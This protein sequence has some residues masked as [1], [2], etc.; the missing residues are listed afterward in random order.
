MPTTR[1]N[2]TGFCILSAALGGLLAGCAAGEPVSPSAPPLAVGEYKVV[3]RWPIGQEGRWDYV[4]VDPRARRLYLP[5]SDRVMVLDADSGKALGQ[6]PNTVGVH[7]VAL[8]PDLGRGFTSNGTA[9]TVTVFDLKT[10]AVL[11]EVYAGE[12]PDAI[13]YDPA[14]QRVFAFNGRSHDATAIVGSADPGHAASVRLAL[15]GKPEFAVVDGRGQLYVNIEDTGEVVSLDTRSLR[16]TARWP[17]A[18]GTEP[19]GLAIDPIHRR[20]FIGCGNQLMVVMN[21][22]SGKVVATLPI[23]QGTDAAAF[24]PE[25]KVAFSSNGDGTLTVVH[26]LGPNDFRVIDTVQTQKSAR[27]MVLDPITHNVYLVAADLNPPVKPGAWPSVVPGTV[28]LLVYGK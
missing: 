10:L 12:N 19:T 27:T 18:P 23:G 1:L 20:L 22:D 28:K 24:D 8:A 4:T 6:V 7:G 16:I 9:G 5:R 26:E 14:S 17:L 13:A 11:G 2:F 21:A 15:G 25:A 3:N